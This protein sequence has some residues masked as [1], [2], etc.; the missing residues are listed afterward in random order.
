MEGWDGSRKDD[1]EAVVLMLIYLLK[2]KL[3]WSDLMG[4]KR[5]VNKELAE[6]V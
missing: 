6:K 3:P 5:D 1:V 2:G 4:G